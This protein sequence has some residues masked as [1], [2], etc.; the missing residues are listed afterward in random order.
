MSRHVLV[1]DDEPDMRL[2]L[3][4]TLGR[5]GFEVTEAATGEEALT[6]VQEASFDLVLLDLNLPGMN[7][8]EVL[9]AWRTAGVVPELPVLIVTADPRPDLDDETVA[10]GGRECLRKPV[11]GPDLIERI[12]A[13][14]APAAATTVDE[15]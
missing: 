12:E 1:V 6:A 5:A 7:G 8:L 2:L 4:L 14:T 11:R 15:R 13:V 3:R 10:R 9:E